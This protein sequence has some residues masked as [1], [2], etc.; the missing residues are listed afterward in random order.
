MNVLNP[1]H[2]IP[3]PGATLLDHLRSMDNKRSSPQADKGE[4]GNHACFP[5]P[6]MVKKLS[7]ISESNDY[8][9]R[10][11]KIILEFKLPEEQEFY[12][13]AIRAMDLRLTLVHLVLRLTAIRHGKPPDI[14]PC[15]ALEPVL[16]AL[17]AKMDMLGLND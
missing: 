12:E 7:L 8:Q 6:E 3:L 15:P 4:T 14:P 9:T 11:S 13:A 1:A 2:R 17:E 5:T 16:R 10:P